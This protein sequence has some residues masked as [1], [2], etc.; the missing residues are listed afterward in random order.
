MTRSELFQYI[1]NEEEQQKADVADGILKAYNASFNLSL[2]NGVIGKERVAP[3]GWGKEYVYTIYVN[4]MGYM[5]VHEVDDVPPRLWTSVDTPQTE[6]EDY[7]PMALDRMGYKY[8]NEYRD[9]K[10]IF[11]N[12]AVK[13]YLEQVL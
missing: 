9:V 8:K 11:E 2:Y 12:P 3:S 6:L 5:C 4:G 7:I 1:M 13:Q 10:E